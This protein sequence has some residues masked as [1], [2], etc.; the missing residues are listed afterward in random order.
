MST[1]LA[2]PLYQY[3]PT[4]AIRDNRGLA[5]RVLAYNR[6][7]ASD[8]SNELISRNH[9]NVLGQLIA[10]RDARLEIDN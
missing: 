2:S 10:S 9:Y 5:I 1:I 4:I 6:T 7:N 8:A 3:T